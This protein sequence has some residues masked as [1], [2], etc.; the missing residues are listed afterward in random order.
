MKLS[1]KEDQNLVEII[2]D[3]VVGVAGEDQFNESLLE[4][5][6]QGGLG[7]SD[8]EA[9]EITRYFEKLIAQGV[10]VNYKS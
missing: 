9:D 8:K 6:S 3:R 4:S 7:M 5:V 1:K 10:D 2:A